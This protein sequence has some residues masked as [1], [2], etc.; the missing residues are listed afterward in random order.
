MANATTNLRKF[1]YGKGGR[2]ITH[3]VDGATHIY[4]GTLVSQLTA[5]GM[6]VPG[7]T[8]SSGGAIGVANH[9][10]DTTGLADADRRL[11]FETDRIFLFANATAGDALSEAKMIG[12]R[13]Y[14]VDDH[15]VANNDNSGAR[16]PAGFFAGMEP[17]GKVRVYVT[18]LSSILVDV[19]TDT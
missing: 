8:P 10:M 19:D 13:V 9:E 14:M 12:S 5:T 17:D 1:P 6:L 15:T 16:Q 4:E 3:A 18:F 7:S 2:D 11:S